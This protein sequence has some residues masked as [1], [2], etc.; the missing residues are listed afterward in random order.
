M[1]S[2]SDHLYAHIAKLQVRVFELEV[3]VAELKT[4]RDDLIRG[5][6]E[7]RRKFDAAG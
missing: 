1:Q 3:T 7:L 6:E 4:W 2:S 5:L